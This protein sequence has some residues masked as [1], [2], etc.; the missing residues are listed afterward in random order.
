[1][2]PSKSSVIGRVPLLIQLTGQERQLLLD[3]RQRKAQLVNEIQQLTCQI[4]NITGELSEPDV[5]L[6]SPSTRYPNHR[7]IN[8]YPP[9][10]TKSVMTN[11]DCLRNPHSHLY[12]TNGVHH[13]FQSNAQLQPDV[14]THLHASNLIESTESLIRTNRLNAISKFLLPSKSNLTGSTIIDHVRP[15]ATILDW[16]DR[17]NSKPIASIKPIILSQ[18]E[19]VDKLADQIDTSSIDVTK[20]ISIAGTIRANNESNVKLGAFSL[21][22]ICDT[23]NRSPSTTSV[24]LLA[25]TIGSWSPLDLARFMLSDVRLTRQAVGHF[26]AQPHDLNQQV[27]QQFVELHDF[28]RLAPHDA[29]R[30]YLGNFHLPG[31]AQ[32]IQRFL[33]PFAAH[34][35]L[36][37]PGRFEHE[38][39]LFLLAYSLLMLNTLRHRPNVQAKLSRRRFCEMNRGVSRPLLRRAYA[40]VCRHPFQ[41]PTDAPTTH[42]HLDVPTY[43]DRSNSC[44]GWLWKR[45][46]SIARFTRWQRRWFVLDERCLFYFVHPSDR[47][48]KGNLP[49]ISTSL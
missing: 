27:L 2:L 34:Y 44:Q 33:E 6:H 14:I 24:R 13:R 41:V 23:F 45:S 37:N 48:P 11:H 25:E 19:K 30:T 49:T 12:Q 9:D 18:S 26:L 39:Q 16:S 17:K 35:C 8:E 36:Q 15:S 20:S 42:N 10:L 4:Q 28:E 40:S 31:E 1:M 43:V 21:K 22:E 7:S 5:E 46:G 47:E 3:I 38:D 32:Q 29:L